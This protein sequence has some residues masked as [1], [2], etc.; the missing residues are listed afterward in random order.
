MPACRGRYRIVFLGPAIGSGT[1]DGRIVSVNAVAKTNGSTAP[2]CVPNEIVCGELGRLLGL[3]VPPGGVVYSPQS[4]NRL[5]YASL[6]FNLTGNTLPPVNT[7]KCVKLLPRESSGLLIFDILIG[8]CDRHNKNISV[9][10]S[11]KPPT[12]NIFDH[13]HALFG[14]DADQGV[15]R[16]EQLRNRLAIS[17]GACTLGNRHC[18]LD[19][20]DTDEH[21]GYW[22]DRIRK[23]PD[24]FVEDLCDE[25][26]GLNCTE[27]EAAAALSF[28]KHRRG[29][30]EHIIEEN[31]DAFTRI[32]T[33]R[34]FR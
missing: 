6:D 34:L 26:T 30:L 5:F 16:L 31:K 2:Y 15:A 27:K 17:G 3:S 29:N 12:M 21:F 22:L 13:G 23:I 18:M 1:T 4:N 20:I 11:K 33:W 7:T 14:K 10:F 25:L 9:D 19:Q 28:L 8:N 24:F 32:Q